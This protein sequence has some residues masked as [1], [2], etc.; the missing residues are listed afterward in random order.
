MLCSC[1]FF[2]YQLPIIIIIVNNNG[3]YGGFDNETY[4]T[5]RS[6]GDASDV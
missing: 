1:D 5:I 4:D 3:I 6:A 2:R